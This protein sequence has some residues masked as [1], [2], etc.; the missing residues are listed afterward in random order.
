MNS[1][2]WPS[3]LWHSAQAPTS[4]RPLRTEQCQLLGSKYTVSSFGD[5]GLHRQMCAS[6]ID[7]LH[8]C[9]LFY[10]CSSSCMMR[11]GPSPPTYTR[12]TEL[13][14]CLISAL[15]TFVFTSGL[16]VRFY[17]AG[18]CLAHFT[19]PHGQLAAAA[20]TCTAHASFVKYLNPLFLLA[21]P[22]VQ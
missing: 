5:N 16:F 8:C 2:L 4:F 15:Y 22:L 6:A 14:R 3:D 19:T 10:F 7:A 9:R 17:A 18:S 1:D 21:Y 20:G 13:L 11:L 12:Y